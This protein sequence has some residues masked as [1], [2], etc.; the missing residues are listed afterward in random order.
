M[1][2]HITHYKT[3]NGKTHKVAGKAAEKPAEKDTTQGKTGQ[4]EAPA[5]Q[6]EKNERT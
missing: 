2:L 3:E 5:K 4:P 6:G 1:S